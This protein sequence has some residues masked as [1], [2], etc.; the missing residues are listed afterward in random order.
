[1]Y[2]AEVFVL[3]Q[4]REYIVEKASLLP[5]QMLCSWKDWFCF[6]DS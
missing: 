2:A 1:M 4:F 6:V 3:M 5:R